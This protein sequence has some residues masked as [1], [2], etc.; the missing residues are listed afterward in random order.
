MEPSDNLLIYCAGHGQLDDFTGD[1]Y[2]I[3]VEGDLKDPSTWMSNAVVKSILSSERLQAKNVMETRAI[4]TSL[5]QDYLSA[6]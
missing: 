3:P 5:I 1:G 4:V 2:W 6:R